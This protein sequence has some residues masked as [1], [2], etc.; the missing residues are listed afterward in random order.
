MI[1]SW[2]FIKDVVLEEKLKDYRYTIEEDRKENEKN[3]TENNLTVNAKNA[4]VVACNEKHIIHDL[5]FVA[6]NVAKMATL[7]TEKLND[8]L[9]ANEEHALAWPILVAMHQIGNQ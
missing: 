3:K 6:D 1:K 4:I 7:T 8:L 9:K 2:Q 5:I